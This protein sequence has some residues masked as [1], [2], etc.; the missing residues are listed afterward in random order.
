MIKISA[1]KNNR[2]VV[3]AVSV[4]VVGLVVYAI[5]VYRYESK[6]LYER[7][8]EQ[9]LDA[10]ESVGYLLPADFHDRALNKDS[11]SLYEYY[12]VVYKL[13]S[14][15]NNYGI[16]YIYTCVKD[17]KNLVF[18]SSSATE[19]ELST[20]VNFT[21]YWDVYSEAD[22]AFYRAFDT[23][24]PIYFEYTD[25]WGTFRT[26][27]LR[28]FSS[29]KHVYIECA[30]YE[31]S[32]IK[33]SLWKKALYAFVGGIFLLLISLPMF[34]ALRKVYR[35]RS[36][37]LKKLV[38]DRT[39][40]LKLEILKRNEIDEKIKYSEEKFSKAFDKSPQILFIVESASGNLVEVNNR[41]IEATGM[42]RNEVI[43]SFVLTVPFFITAT[44]Y[45]YIKK[46][47]DEKGYIKELEI[48]FKCRSENCY[49]LLYAEI[50]QIKNRKHVLYIVNDITK[51]KKLE[52]E[53]VKAK[54][55]AETSDR[56]K[57]AFLSNMSHEI[58]TPMNSI[59][60][61][62][63]L[64]RNDDLTP[65]KR[66]EF[67]DIIYSNGNSLLAIINDIIDFSKIEA[68]QL[69]INYNDVFLNPLMRNLYN[70]IMR[71]RVDR[72]RQNLEIGLS[73]TLEENDSYIRIDDIRIT[74]IL[75]NL[76]TNAL[77]FTE[78]GRIDFGY[79]LNGDFIRFYVKDTGI[80]IPEDKQALI[81][82]RFQQLIETKTRQYI[83]TGLGLSISKA[84]V[85]LMGGHIW[86]ESKVDN[87]SMFFFDIP[88]RK[89]RTE[90]IDA[91]S[92]EKKPA[93]TLLKG[94]S[95]LIADDDKS[96]L[97]LLRHIVTREGAVVYT[98]NSG[99]EVLEVFRQNKGIKLVLLDINMPDKDGYQVMKELKREA[100]DIKIVF[101]TALAMADERQVIQNSGC[102]A[103][104]F[105]PINQKELIETLNRLLSS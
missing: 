96:S 17:G 32:S 38:D 25:R 95:V 99:N 41:F 81:F 36:K 94:K 49:G 22:E 45:E 46:I 5:A 85:E 39:S 10:A 59:I 66:A 74:Q 33:A 20:G 14:H 77:K 31:I 47:I 86:V 70:V 82:D 92:S 61:F 15:V 76:L 51:A 26:V 12:E 7:V 60:G 104:L 89:P 98:A 69:K 8:D 13:S 62:T 88:F 103:C 71:E 3:F 21:R 75:T 27:A 42:K 97:T 37:D 93:T 83:G 40:E 87:G 30:D 54:E 100:K 23:D 34:F 28:K 68:G 58:R 91:I 53:V 2:L 19:K 52:Q 63:S 102:D 16:K 44:D 11:I 79:E 48:S 105:K 4:Y 78:T 56:L 57:S 9:L 80:G 65:Q 35:E 29:R 64:L 55:K 43:G 6:K 50:I 67:L 73:L 84:L 1:L 24:E 101:Q 18:T 90:A 72:G